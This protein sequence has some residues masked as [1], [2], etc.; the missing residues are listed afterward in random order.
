MPV[1]PRA[2]GARGRAARPG[3]R[4]R[5][6]EHHVPHRGRR[7]GMGRE[8]GVIS[9][10]ADTEVPVPRTY[11]LCE[12]PE[13]IGAPFYVM[14]YVHGVIP[15]DPAAFARDYDE[16]ACRRLGE[17][18]IDTLAAL[19]A[20]DPAAVGLADFGRPQGYVERQVRRFSEQLA[21]VKTRDVPDMEEIARRLPGA[22]PPD[23]D[24]TI[25][26]GDFRLDNAVVDAEGHLAA[27]LDWEMST[28]GD[29][30]MDLG[31]LRMYWRD[32]EPV[33]GLAGVV[34]S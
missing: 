22:I 24:A 5:Q 16:P 21:K 33:D 19:H 11:A 31:I 30:L 14:E 27:V 26:H 34:G 3:D 23:G 4:P 6:V 15:T 25:V 12:D 7:P 18:L 10:V 29:P 1:V 20:L 9:A 8:F 32:R 13:V 17:E 2:R 28:L